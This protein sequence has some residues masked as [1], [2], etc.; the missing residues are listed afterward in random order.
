MKRPLHFNYFLLSR[1][2]PIAPEWELAIAGKG[3]RQFQDVSVP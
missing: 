3:N 1:K 2:I